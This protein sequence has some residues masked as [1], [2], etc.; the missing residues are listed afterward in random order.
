[1]NVH[2]KKHFIPTFSRSSVEAESPNSA[3]GDQYN[4]LIY[5]IEGGNEAERFAID[6]DTGAVTVSAALDYESKPHHQLTVRATEGSSGGYA[7]AVLLIGVE[8]VNDCAPRFKNDSYE[9][10]VSEA[11]PAGTPLLTVSASD[12]DSGANGEVEFSILSEAGNG[13]ASHLFS[14]H[15]ESGVLSLRKSLDHE[16]AREHRFT[17]VAKDRGP[18]QMSSTAPVRII[19]EDANDNPP[20]FEEA[21]YAFR[22]SDTAERGQFVGK[23]RAVDQDES[24]S[25]K[26]RYVIILRFNSTASSLMFESFH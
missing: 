25:D 24:D 15:P 10:V 26:L 9:A 13:N 5:T 2:A 19:V 23:V 16:H 21:G 22:L 4:K 7:E 20:E 3:G 11:M 6:Y 12:A 8:D 18:G 14:V 17:V 1:M